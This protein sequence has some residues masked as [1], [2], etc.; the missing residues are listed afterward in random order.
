MTWFSVEHQDA[1][2]KTVGSFYGSYVR[3]QLTAGYLIQPLSNQQ[4]RVSAVL[5][6]ELGGGMMSA[7]KERAA[8]EQPEDSLANLAKRFLPGSKLGPPPPADAAAYGKLKAVGEHFL[9]PADAAAT[10]PQ[11]QPE[12]ESR[13]T[14]S[15]VQATVTAVAVQVIDR[16]P[17]ALA[18]Q[19]TAAATQGAGG[20]GAAAVG[21]VG[22]GTTAVPVGS[23]T[24]PQQ[25]SFFAGLP[26]VVRLRALILGTV[27]TYR[28]SIPY[29]I[30]IWSTC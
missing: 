24:P 3:A 25:L 17:G 14:R 9:W 26:P 11:P 1:T 18:V 19:A 8:R 2:L 20:G 23:A 10:Q 12:P 4:C 27:R 15:T 30:P 16:A 29:L 28:G 6:L 22:L 21:A 13:D 7:I 5:R